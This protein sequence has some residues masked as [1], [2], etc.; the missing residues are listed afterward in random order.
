MNLHK[1]ASPSKQELEFS[2]ASETNII[3]EEVY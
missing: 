3:A 1:L 2:K